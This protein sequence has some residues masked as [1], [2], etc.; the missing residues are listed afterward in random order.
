MNKILVTTTLLSSR[1]PR[2]P[3]S[4]WAGS[5][6][7]PLPLSFSLS[8]SPFSPSPFLPSRLRAVPCSFRSRFAP[9]AVCAL[10]LGAAARSLSA[11][12]VGLALWALACA[13]CSAPPR[14]L[15]GF[16]EAQKSGGR[17]RGEG[18]SL[19]ER[20]GTDGGKGRRKEGEKGAGGG[21]PVRKV[22][23]PA[24]M[25][26]GDNIQNSQISTRLREL[27]VPPRVLV[28]LLPT[29]PSFSTRAPSS[30]RGSAGKTHEMIAGSSVH[31]ASSSTC[32]HSPGDPTP[33]S[34]F[35]LSPA[36]PDSMEL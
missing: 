22:Q 35:T 13:P 10:R 2:L 12:C 18:R 3:C 27:G 24:Q 16:A 7:S 21:G 4:L 33:L 19:R 32:R 31:A 14:G 8:P 28:A 9:A 36:C 20:G 34:K 5:G 6:F 26:L 30:P 17:T 11:G 25:Y 1:C 29:V 15:R 23:K